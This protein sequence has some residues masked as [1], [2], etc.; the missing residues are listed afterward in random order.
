MDFADKIKT[1]AA[2]FDKIKNHVATEEATK[3]SMVMPFIQTLGYDIFNSQE[4]IPECG[5]AFGEKKD[6]RVDYAISFNEGQ[7]STILIEV[8]KAE[9]PLQLKSIDELRKYF[10]ASEAKF[11]I[12]TNG[13]QYQFF[14]DLD[15]KHLIDYSG[16]NRPPIPIQI[17]HPIRSKSAGYSGANQASHLSS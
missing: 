16:S 6:A 2:K 15:K 12:L 3:T 10:A 9:T 14:A 17:G 8:K 1:L 11:A 5:A 7:D 13:I 4:V